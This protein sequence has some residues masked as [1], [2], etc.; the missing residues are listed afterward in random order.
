MH[1]FRLKMVSRNYFTPLWV[2]GTY[3]KHT[4]RWPENKTLLSIK[5][6]TLLFYLQW[7]SRKHTRRERVRESSSTLHLKWF[8]S[9]SLPV[10]SPSSSPSREL[11]HPKTE[12]EQEGKVKKTAQPSPVSDP[13]TDLVAVASFRPTHRSCRYQT[14]LPISPLSDPPTHLTSFWPTHKSVVL[15]LSL[16]L[17]LSLPLPLS[18]SMLIF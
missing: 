16:S 13:P 12:R 17:N 1:L 2:F 15:Y 18:R 5:L 3:G 8:P 10:R 14:H 11:T 6:F 9:T 7:I 4:P